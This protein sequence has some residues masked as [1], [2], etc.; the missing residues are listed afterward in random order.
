MAL[1]GAGGK[2]REELDAALDA[3]GA[4]LEVETRPDSTRFEGEVLARNLDAFLALLADMLLR[5]TFAPAE[6]ARTQREIVAQ[7]EELRTD[8]HA[9]CAR[10]F[11]RNLYG[12]HPYGH[13]PD[14]L[15]AASR[16]RRAD[17]V[18]A[19]FKRTSWGA[20]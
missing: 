13:P 19:H 7:I 3:L 12:D 9:L 20:T 5:P 18:A 6:L 15:P 14:G 10:F 17:E 16:P 1:R 2:T 8:D 4:T 11:A